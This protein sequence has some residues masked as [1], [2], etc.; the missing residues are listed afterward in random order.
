MNADQK[1]EREERAGKYEIRTDH[2][3]PTADRPSLNRIGDLARHAFFLIYPRSSAFICVHL[4]SS[5]AL[6]RILRSGLLHCGLQVGPMPIRVEFFGI[7]RARAG[8]PF[9][10]IEAVTLGDVFRQVASRGDLLNEVC[11]ADG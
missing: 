1:E 5:A 6:I 2:R 10:E 9:I 4:R 3:L 8:V 11:S 7:A